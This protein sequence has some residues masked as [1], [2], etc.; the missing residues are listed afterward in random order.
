M[1]LILVDLDNTLVDRVS[2]FGRWA[3]TFLDAFQ[4]DTHLSDEIRAIDDDGLRPRQEFY[5][6]LGEV[7]GGMSPDSIR[8]FYLDKYPSSFVLD[9]AVIDGLRR[10]K[11]VGCRVWIVSNGPPFQAHVIQNT[12]LDPM[13]PTYVGAGLSLLTLRG[14][15]FGL[16]GPRIVTTGTG[17]IV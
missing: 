11:Q 7:C 10:L 17:G 3:Y 4:L 9:D 2:A 16:D 6:M 1:T 8:D 15:R 5:D 14:D 12:G 13:P